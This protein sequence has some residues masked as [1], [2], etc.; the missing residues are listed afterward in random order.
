MRKSLCLALLGG[1]AAGGFAA[2]AANAADDP[3]GGYIG[4]GF[5]K[6]RVNDVYGYGDLNIDKTS[7]KALV[8]VSQGGFAFEGDY[9]NFGSRTTAFNHA[10]AKA[11]AGYA[12]LSMPIKTFSVF[13]KLGVARYQLSGAL[14]NGFAFDQHANEFAWGGGAQVKYNHLAARLEYERFNISNADGAVVYGLS[15]LYMF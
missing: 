13:G 14:N 2:G 12:V 1:L 9:Y 6:P 4:A 5:T 15:L 11:F 8:G 10:D 3:I 7:W